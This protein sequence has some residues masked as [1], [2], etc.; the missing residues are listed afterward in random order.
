MKRAILTATLAGTVIALAGCGYDEGEYNNAAYDEGNAAYDEG[1]AAYN[2]AGN[3]AYG[4]ASAGW[5]EGA[6]I[7]EENGVL[8]RVD[9]GGA[10][11]VLQPGESRIVVE[12][13]VRFR[14]D[15]DGTR[16]RI[17]EEG[18]AIRVDGDDGDATVDVNAGVDV[19]TN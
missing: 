5:P 3:D 14:I 11:V 8:Y 4:T 6:R 16:V 15:P 2:A 1:N 18:L 19:N 7:V 10:R 17:D 9:P 12:D 13:G